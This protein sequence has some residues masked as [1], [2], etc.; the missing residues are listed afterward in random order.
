M[1]NWKHSHQVLSLLLIQLSFIGVYASKDSYPGSISSQPVGFSTCRGGTASA[2]SVTVGATVCG[3]SGGTTTITRTFTWYQTS[4][5]C[6]GG[7][8]VQTTSGTALTDTYTPSVTTLGTQ[9]YYCKITWSAG[10]NC[11]PAGTLTSNCATVTVTN[12][13]AKTWV[14]GATWSTATWSPAGAPGTCDSVVI[15]SGASVTCSG[16]TSI[17]SLTI[18][19]GGS[20]TT[21]SAITINSTGYFTI[22]NG[23]TYTNSNSSAWTTTIFNGT[24]SFGASSTIIVNS[25]DGNGN[26][27]SSSSSNFGNV[28]YNA[29]AGVNTYEIESGFGITRTVQGNLVIGSTG[30]LMCSYQQNGNQT[31]SVGGNMDVQGQIRI[32]EGSI[33]DLAVSVGGNITNSGYIYFI[34]PTATTNGQGNLTV[35]AVNLTSSGTLYSSYGTSFGNG[36]AT[37][38]LTG[39]FTQSGGTVYGSYGASGNVS[40]TAANFTISSGTFYGSYVGSGSLTFNISSA[41]TVSGTGTLLG[42]YSGNGAANITAGSFVHSGN[43]THFVD[44]GTGTV[45]MTINGNWTHS[46]GQCV[47]SYYPTTGNNGTVN[48]TVTG[49]LTLT[50][51]SIILHSNDI[52]DGRSCSMTINGNASFTF[53]SS[54]DF[55]EFNNISNFA[56]NNALYTLTVGGNLTVSGSTSGLFNTRWT[57]TGADNIYITGDMTLSGGMTSFSG[58][59]SAA[60]TAMP[61]NT[62]TASV[63]GNVSITGAAI[64]FSQSSNNSSKI[65]LNVGTASVTWQQ[66]TTGTVQIT[67]LNVLSGKTVTMTGSKLGSI[68]TGRTMTVNSGATLYCDVYPV[69]GAGAFT[70]SSGAYIGIGNIG[71]ITTSGATGNIQVTSTRTY[72]SNASYEYYLGQTPQVTGSFTTTTTSGTYP[73]QVTNL[74][75]NKTNASDIVTLTNT[76]DMINNGTLTLT[77]GVLTTSYTAAT[78]PWIRIPNNSTSVSPSG[79]SANSYVDGYIRKTGN[80]A[81]IF[82][83]GNSGYWRRIEITAPSAS[84]E[85][86]ARYIHSAYV[87]TTTMAASPSMVLDHV[88]KIEYWY[89]SKPLGADV[90][91]TKVKL[92]WENAAASGIYKFDSLTVARWNGSA[93]EDAN[94]YS[95]CPSDWISS[96]PERTYTGSATAFGAGTIRS[97]TV[98]SFSPFTFASTGV[99]ELNPLP[100]T[101]TTFTVK[102]VQK[103]AVIKWTTATEINNRFFTIERSRNGVDFTPLM[104]VNSQAVNGNS[105]SPLYY[106]AKDN[107]PY[108]G[109]SYYR[110]KQTDFDGK[111]NYS[112]VVAV[113]NIAEGT[114]TVYPNPAR[115]EMNIVMPE[116]FKSSRAVVEVYDV[117]GKIVLSKELSSAEGSNE[118]RLDISSLDKGVYLVSV[119]SEDGRLNKR[120]VKE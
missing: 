97:N 72:N 55:F 4:T 42:V 52:T 83:T 74:I 67:N 25:D 75:I 20:V 38:S 118:T 71:G 73:V 32:K 1:L 99:Y 94:C 110:L 103:A 85:F 62:L 106:N 111:F 45:T 77:K 96:Q 102:L 69:S 23:G 54:S 79:G 116:G 34:F 35:S 12:Y 19:S 31:F 101:L 50:G 60:G 113:N 39:T 91:T 68:L 40:V 21:S 81:F 30:L 119:L 13:S 28:T 41:L 104:D 84:T 49:N 120:V 107:A 17:G 66:T 37:Y 98:S 108:T 47:P 95:S 51:G 8:V 64:F 16:A 61:N 70:L 14:S 29:T 65:D 56:T 57:N 11:A 88:S 114:L 93:W 112:G 27:T 86:E 2:L 6:S 89:L 33:G 9:Y 80:G 43:I 59:S 15:P 105:T 48:C 36:N 117:A 92:Y 22:N 100:V 87:N 46:A 58:G 44:G 26:M 78:A 76:T 7:S 5:S 63:G 90:A 82:P 53:A 24:E 10:A 3:A 109:I 115:D 18:L